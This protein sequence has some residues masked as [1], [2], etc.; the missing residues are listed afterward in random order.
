MEI[1]G[2]VVDVIFRNADNGYSVVELA[3][4]GKLLTAVGKFP[5]VTE[6]QDLLLEGSYVMNPQFGQ[7][8]SA[9]RISIA[10]PTSEESIIRYL[11]GGLFKGV[12]EVTAAAIVAEFGTDTLKVIESDPAALSRVRGVSLK[13]AME[14]NTSYHLLSDMQEA[15]LFLQDLDISLNMAIKIYRI[16]EGDTKKI[17]TA[18]P[19]RLVED[20]DGIGF[21]TADKIAKSLGIRE[22]SR[23]RITAAI[24]YTLKE[25][26]NK[27]GHTYLPKDILIKECGR[28]LRLGR[29]DSDELIN[30]VVDEI[31]VSGKIVCL[32]KGE[33]I[34]VLLS[35]FYITERAIAG[36]IVRL[37]RTRN[38]LDDIS[39]RDD[40]AEYERINGITLHE[41]QKAAIEGCLSDGISVVTGGPGT[42][43]TTIIKC[44]ISILKSRG[45]KFALCAPTG[46]ASKRLTEATGEE[47][48]T[49]H[50]MLDLAFGEGGA[51]SF[52]ER[53]K[54]DA[55]VVIVDEVSMCDE[56]VFSA[57]L[58]AMRGGASLIM[59]GDKDQLPSVGAGNVLA[60]VIACN[61]VNVYCLTQIYR[62]EEGSLIISNAHAINRGIMPTIDNRSKDFFFGACD[63][64]DEILHTVID[65]VTKRI[66]S[67]TSLPPE[68]IQVL[69]PMKKGIAGV[70]SLN[71]ALQSALNPKEKGKAELKVGTSVFRTGDKIIHTVN[72]YSL[73][74]KNEDD[75]SEG[76]GVY[77][78]D[79]GYITDINL[80]EPSVTVQFEDGKIAKYTQ[81]S[82]DQI[83][84][85]YAVSVHKSQGCE[86]PV[87]VLALMKGHYIVMT[88]NLL[89]TAVTRAQKMVVIL[90]AKET[91]AG[92]VS[93]TYTSRRYSMLCD[94]ITETAMR[95]R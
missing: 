40:I 10:P 50:R 62:Q 6:G 93:N 56:Y 52:D 85:A 11:S 18:N 72:N 58:S 81:G 89:Y 73:E 21:L 68:K 39:V 90:G 12:G 25:A 29:I 84:L 69:C 65:M 66:P 32:D 48:K 23:F 76:S 95:D 37:S 41:G 26:T 42:G 9:T 33:H 7:Q 92:M 16:Y 74:W 1:K 60:D 67:F 45:K 53:T 51:F 34:A 61:I 20:V 83:K 31:E 71:E 28:L 55:D 47:A 30:D 43:K 79:I 3:C 14:I 63:S 46:R 59:V 86:F 35:G 88:R 19:Y 4:K 57:L 80:A 15:I 54:L 17:V 82:F 22:D 2:N 13:K 75:S 24:I 44:I 38:N 78:G 8:F 49:I 94:F 36:T 87:V 5:P 64:A 77:N 91:L 70:E 27:N